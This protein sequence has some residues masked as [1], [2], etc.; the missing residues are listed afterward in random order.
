MKQHYE[1]AT[2]AYDIQKY[3]EAVEEYQRAYEIGGDP[4]M[5]FN[6][7]Q[8]YRLNDQFSEAMR[9]YKRYLQRSQRRPRRPFSRR[10]WSC[11]H[12]RR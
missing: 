2:R 11:G 8:A 7:A 10:R 5:L 9:F 1:R 12:R 4:A 6:I 3:Q